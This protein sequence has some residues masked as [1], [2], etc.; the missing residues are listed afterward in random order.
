MAGNEGKR[1]EAKKAKPK[2]HKKK[3][4]AAE[5]STLPPRKA[6]KLEAF[7]RHKDSIKPREALR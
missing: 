3:I 7:V 6:M 5:K 1:L 4:L 2:E